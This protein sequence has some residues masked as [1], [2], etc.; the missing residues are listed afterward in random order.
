MCSG[1]EAVNMDAQQWEYARHPPDGGG[2]AEI[3]TE[4]RV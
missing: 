2:A 1:P 3:G 4:R